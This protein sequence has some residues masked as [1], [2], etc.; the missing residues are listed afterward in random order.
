MPF[1]DPL[2]RMECEVSQF[3]V[4]LAAELA[5]VRTKDTA[6]AADPSMEIQILPQRIPGFRLRVFCDTAWSA[7]RRP[8]GCTWPQYD[9]SV[10]VARMCHLDSLENDSLREQERKRGDNLEGRRPACPWIEWVQQSRRAE[11][12]NSLPVRRAP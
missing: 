5:S 2:L 6:A 12:L 3:D 8:E 1:R 9:D 4:E 10:K 7:M 11:N